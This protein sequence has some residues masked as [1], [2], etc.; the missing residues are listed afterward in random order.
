MA[1]RD[2]SAWETPPPIPPEGLVSG[3]V[4]TDPA[5]FADEMER[6]FTPGWRL[7]CH[8]SELPE[9]YDYRTFDH[10]GQPLFCIRDGDGQ[11][12]TFINACSHRG[13]RLLSDPAGNARRITCFYHHWSYDAKGSCIAVPRA[14]G[15][16]ASGLDRSTLGL[17]E[18]RT[19]IR[20]GL[21]FITMD[22]TAEALD[23]SLAGALA[24]FEPIMGGGSL[25]A[26]HF[27]R[28]LLNCNWK[29]WQETNLDLYHENMHV[30]LRKTQR[31]AMPM[32]DRHIRIYGNGH[33]GSGKMVAA[34]GGYQGFAGRGSDVPPLPGTDAADFRFSVLFPS[35]AILSRGTVMRIDTVIPVSPSQT[36]LEMRGLG[37]KGDTDADRRVRYRHFNQ[38]WGPMGRNVPEDMF[39]AEACEASFRHQAARYQIIARDEGLT[40]QDDAPLRSFYAEWARL[41]HRD[42]HAPHPV[43]A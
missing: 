17:R 23:K 2:A 27:S 4:Y 20:L 34:Y 36:I 42:A 24:P 19:E 29:A 43:P 25:E 39:A 33:A 28:S 18:I 32:A 35:S 38:Y 10:A 14:E 15:Y 41:M 13:A 22:S 37:L 30:V 26:I 16:A 31:D 21:V 40:G 11:I 6:I 8:E 9:P 12:R 3:T 5:I 7:A 1:A